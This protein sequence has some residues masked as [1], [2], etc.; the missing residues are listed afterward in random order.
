MRYCHFI[1]EHF[2]SNVFMVLVYIYIL[3]NILLNKEKESENIDS[4]IHCT[5]VSVLRTYH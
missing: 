5:L 3:Q 4:S 2:I 1:F